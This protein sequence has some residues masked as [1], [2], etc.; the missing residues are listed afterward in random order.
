MALFEYIEDEEVRA[1][2]VADYEAQM[3]TI[4]ADIA[5]KIETAV[6]GLKTKNDEL[7]NEKKTIQ[8]R[9]KDFADIEDPKKAKEAL[10]FF[11]E[12]SEAQM[13]KDG[14]I[15]ELIQIKTA[16][17]R[18]DT[19]A[20]MKELQKKIGEASTTADVYK[21]QYEKKM[22]EDH[23]RGVALKAGV[24]PHAVSD[25]LLRGGGVFSLGANGEVESRDGDGKLRKTPDDMI[26]TSDKWIAGLKE[27]SPHYWPA[28]K[29]GGFSGAGGMDT[30]DIQ[31]KLADLAAKGD[32]A[33]YKALR[34][35]TRGKKQ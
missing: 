28:S 19:E 15:D 3:V 29:G 32:M 24:L 33:G 30:D 6:Q 11:Q 5:T 1:K 27:T 14:R 16:T 23:L 9:L 10:K 12:S 31:T 2:A 17:F 13:I 21:S 26:M 25:I 20:A 34:E 4:N 18:A 35:K 22:V 7:L 8:E